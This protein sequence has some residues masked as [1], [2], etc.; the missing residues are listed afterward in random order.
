VERLDP[1]TN[2][3]VTG[4]VMD[5]PFSGDVLDSSKIATYT[6]LFNNG[7]TSSVPISE[8]A[9]IIPSPSVRY[10]V[11]NKTHVLLPP[12]LQLSSKITYQHKG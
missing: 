4:T 12:F 5:V 11:V 1:S 3:L 9:S 10:R 8:M 6:I 2:I 7:K